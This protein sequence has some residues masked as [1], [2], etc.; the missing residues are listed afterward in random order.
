MSLHLSKLANR[1]ELRHLLPLA[2]EVLSRIE[3]ASR[4]SQFHLRDPSRRSILQFRFWVRSHAPEASYMVD[5]FDLG[6]LACNKVGG[7]SEIYLPHVGL[8]NQ[9]LCE[10]SATQCSSDVSRGMCRRKPHSNFFSRPL[11]LSP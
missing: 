1:P 9:E 8:W 7:S 10:G 4:M 6:F 11:V 5:A 3:V 2:W